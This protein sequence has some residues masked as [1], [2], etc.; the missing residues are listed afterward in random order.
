[1]LNTWYCDPSNS[2]TEPDHKSKAKLYTTCTGSYTTTRMVVSNGTH[3]NLWYGPLKLKMSERKIFGQ[4]KFSS[5][6]TNLWMDVFKNARQSCLHSTSFNAMGPGPWLIIKMLSYQYRKAHYGD[7]TILR[8]S[9]LHNEISYTGKTASLYWSGALVA[10][11]CASEPGHQ[12]FI[13]IAQCKTE[14]PP[15]LTHWS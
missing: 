3:S 7:K 15:L 13:S 10:Q 14:A 5:S 12:W 2:C 9:Y 1:M 4:I 8:P 6:K 11:I